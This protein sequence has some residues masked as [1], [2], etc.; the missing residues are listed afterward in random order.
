[1]ESKS[2]SSN[3]R[4]LI[5]TR[6]ETVGISMRLHTSAYVSIRQHT[7]AYVSISDL[8]VSSTV[9]RYEHTSAYVRIRPHTSAYVS[10]S[11]CYL[12]VSST[13]TVVISR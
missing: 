7:S 9:G 1:L 6:A 10:R 3:F 12:P 4:Y 11:Y 2:K 8:P 5:A 13:E